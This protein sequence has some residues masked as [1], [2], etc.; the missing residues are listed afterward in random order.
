MTDRKEPPTKTENR[1]GGNS[2]IHKASITL[3]LNVGLLTVVRETLQPA[4]ASLWLQ[5]ARVARST[6]EHDR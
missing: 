4:H 1:A 3:R 6:G 2:E 5:P